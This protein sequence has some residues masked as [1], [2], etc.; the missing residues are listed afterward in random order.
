MSDE[1]MVDPVIQLA[2]A[3]AVFADALYEELAER[4][5]SKDGALKVVAEAVGNLEMRF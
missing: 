5:W 1:V 4:G 2:K 3:V